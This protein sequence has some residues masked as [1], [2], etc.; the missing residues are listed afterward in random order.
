MRQTDQGT[1]TTLSYKEFAAQPRSRLLYLITLPPGDALSGLV[2]MLGDDSWRQVPAEWLGTL[3]A[4]VY[5]RGLA[6]D[7]G[8]RELRTRFVDAISSGPVGSEAHVTLVQLLSNRRVEEETASKLAKWFVTR[9]NPGDAALAADALRAVFALRREEITSAMLPMIE[10]LVLNGAAEL[11]ASRRGTLLHPLIVALDHHGAAPDLVIASLRYFRVSDDNLAAHYPGFHRI[12]ELL[13]AVERAVERSGNSQVAA[14]L[15]LRLG[16]SMTRPVLDVPEGGPVYPRVRRAILSAMTAGLLG[17]APWRWAFS[18]PCPEPS[19]GVAFGSAEAVKLALEAMK[20]WAC[21]PLRDT[22]P[23]TAE[24]PRERGCVEPLHYER[25]C[26]HL[27]ASR[28]ADGAR[29]TLL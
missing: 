5:Q 8:A 10:W 13:H 16:D 28:G 15:A 11:R 26:S 19:D 25:I 12:D 27:Q 1:M 14:G 17:P 4:L 6:D 9:A 24:P 18:C 21:P 3:D 20:A 22:P 7:P 2:R 23:A 29:A